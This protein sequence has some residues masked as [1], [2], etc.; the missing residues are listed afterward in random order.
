MKNVIASVY[1]LILSTALFANVDYN[2]LWGIANK[3][4][5]QKNYDSAVIY[6]EKIAASHPQD[7][8]IYYNLGNAYYKLNQITPA[9]I[10]Y[11]M[12]L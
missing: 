5:S 9:I 2:K 4:Y 6:Y 8:V 10:N 3:H 1:L 11:E 12:A 7:A